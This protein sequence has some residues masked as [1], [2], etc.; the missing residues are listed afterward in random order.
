MIGQTQDPLLIKTEQAIMAKV[1]P[2]LQPIVDKALHR[3]LALIYSPLGHQQMVAQ[4]DKPGNP[5]ANVAEGAVKLVGIIYQ[6]SKGT[7]PPS[8]AVPTA[9]ILMCEGLDFMEKAKGMKVTP[10]TLA[11]AGQ[12]LGENLLKL[13]G[14]DKQ[15]LQQ[16]ALQSAQR[17][18]QP[19]ATGG[20]VNGARGA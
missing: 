15:K 11:Q 10:D 7:L 14:V 20:I 4:L 18:K 6:E 19:A 17:G 5:L 9:V 13:F 12:A 16:A 2:K 1:P 3:G 8:A